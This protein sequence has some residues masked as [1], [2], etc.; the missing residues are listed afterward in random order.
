M[1]TVPKILRIDKTEIIPLADFMAKIPPEL[2]ELRRYV[3][4]KAVERDGKPTKEPRRAGTNI[5]AST[6]D[7]STWKAAP[8][9]IAGLLTRR[10]FADGI[11]IV[12]GE[13][14]DGR[15]LAGI[16]LDK[17]DGSLPAEADQILERR[18]SYAEHSPNG[19]IHILGF[20][21][22]P[23]HEAFRTGKVERY[24]RDRYL[25]FTGNRIDGAPLTLANIDHEIDLVGEIIKGGNAKPRPA[26]S[27]A[28]TRAVNI[29]DDAI[30]ERAKQARNGAEFSA[31]FGG[32]TG[33]HGGDDSAADLALCSRLAFWFGRDPSR[34]DAAFRRSG[35]YREKWER[36]DYRNRTIGKA[37]ESCHEVYDP[38]RNGHAR[39]SKTPTDVVPQISVEAT[40][41]ELPFTEVGNGRRLVRRH[42]DDLRFIVGLERWHVWN[43]CHWEPDQLSTVIA[44][45]KGVA[46]S[47]LDLARDAEPERRQTVLRFFNETSRERKI[48]ALVELAKSEPGISILPDALDADD[49][50][51]GHPTCTTDLKT[52]QQRPP[53]REDLI[54]K[55]T[56]VD[57]IDGPCPLWLSVLHRSFAGNAAL[58]G[59][60]RRLCGLA[61]TG[62]ASVQELWIAHGEGANGKGT[63]VDA[64]T[65]AMGDYAGIA[66]DSLLTTTRTEHPTD[67]ATCVGKR[68]VV[69]SE[70]ESNAELRLQLLK[71]LT[72]D[73]RLTAR[74]MRRDYFEFRRTFKL[75]I[76]TNNR[77]AVR[78]NTE[79]AWRR[80]RLL[81][82]DVVIPPAERDLYLFQKL[83]KEW[84]QILHW[85]IGG[86]L[87]FQRVGMDP[88]PEVLAATEAYRAESDPAAE[89]VADRLIVSP[90]CRLSRNELASDYAS[91][92]T[93]T[94]NKNPLGRNEL[95]AAIRSIRGVSEKQWRDVAVS[96][97]VR[98][99][100][101]IGLLAVGYNNCGDGV[102]LCNSAKSINS[103]Y[104]HAGGDSKPPDTKCFTASTLPDADDFERA[105]REAIQ[106]EGG[107]E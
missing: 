34:I 60:F 101:G 103:I 30:I 63:L 56:A 82:F 100:V 16:D 72:G 46:D 79:A 105:E 58:I 106:A 51:I 89:Y 94:G 40:V 93:T 43:G 57:P 77:P 29:D 54:S 49:W 61:L 62:D 95:M 10:D 4:W 20:I 38:S 83:Q 37:I 81:P 50:L 44:W 26:I 2:R 64:I 84:P 65:G 15:I 107:A 97:P 70:T 12:L 41:D 31:L 18:S 24:C 3:T 11:G 5:R 66:P 92:C 47:L 87:E 74:Y 80:L 88:P 53:R 91:Y 14:P 98:G 48:A 13:L 36:S 32:D 35:L 7:P 102:T 71:K 67:I 33:G 78:E 99:F 73:A 27:P 68:L 59:Y 28:P 69:G 1:N 25:T 17:K 8:E 23:F 39:K 104:A 90:K 42:G 96:A 22:A 52:G 75:L 86:C 9:A 76:L 45:G 6:T 55:S 85:C 19:G 21:D